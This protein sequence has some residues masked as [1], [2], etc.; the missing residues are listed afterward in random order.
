MITTGVCHNMDGVGPHLSADNEEEGAPQMS[1][2]ISDGLGAWR[3]RYNT[4]SVM[5]A[6]MHIL[7]SSISAV[8]A[9][10]PSQGHCLSSLLLCFYH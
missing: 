7:K 9:P 8:S 1:G 3:R 6:F 2:R 5:E 10:M 4:M